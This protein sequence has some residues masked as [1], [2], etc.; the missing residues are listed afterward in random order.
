MKLI[1]W[2]RDPF[3]D[4]VS[5]GTGLGG[6]FGDFLPALFGDDLLSPYSS[7][8]P[9]VDVREDDDEIV[10]TA[11]APGMKEKELEVMVEDGTLT[12]SGE[13][14]FENEDKR[15]GYH[16]IERRYGSFK[17][18]FRLPAA[19]KSDDIRADYRDGVLE[20]HVPK[21]EEAKGRKIPVKTG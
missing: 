8:L 21:A 17:R 1:K 12:I 19:V 13:K 16:R 2:R 15:E 4:L 7:W 3:D 11:E 14:K 9:P 20:V 10:I 18:S 5:L 6:V